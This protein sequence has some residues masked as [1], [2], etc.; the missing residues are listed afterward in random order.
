IDESAYV[1]YGGVLAHT[2]LF[3]SL[4]KYGAFINPSFS[5]G[6][7]VSVLEAASVGLMLVLSDIRQ[8]R[9]L[10]FPDAVYVRPD[11]DEIVGLDKIG[12][13]SAA[14]VEVVKNRYSINSTCVRYEEIYSK[15]AGNI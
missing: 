9:D 5:E 8:H 7:P 1:S 11:A 12:G 10:G 13:Y 2:D 14:N 15:I 4:S 3:A 6:M